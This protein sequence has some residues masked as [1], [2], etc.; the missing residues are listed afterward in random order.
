M[1]RIEISQQ[2]GRISMQTTLPRVQLQTT[3]PQLQIETEAATVEISREKGGLT[4]DQTQ[5]R[6]SRGWKT[7]SAFTRDYAQAGA[8]AAQEATAK[9]A[10]DGDRMMKIHTKENVIRELAQESNMPK[11][12]DVTW[13]SV[14]LPDIQYTPDQLTF[15]PVPGK[16]SMRY[17][18]GSV[19]TEL[20]RGGVDIQMAQY[21]SVTM[22]VVDLNA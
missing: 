14:T 15:R 22:Q 13:A 21:P 8:Q 20:Q 17:E 9:A 18:L 4:I 11:P 1:A 2:Q 3:R 6:Y 7:A 16:I 5:T 19:Q 12:V 10:Q